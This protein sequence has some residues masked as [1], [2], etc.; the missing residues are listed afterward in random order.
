MT[1]RILCRYFQDGKFSQIFIDGIQNRIIEHSERM[2]LRGSVPCLPGVQSEFAT[3]RTDCKRSSIGFHGFR[4][5]KYL[6]KHKCCQ[7]RIRV[8]TDGGHGPRASAPATQ[9][10]PPEPGAGQAAAEPRGPRGPLEVSLRVLFWVCLGFFFFFCKPLN[11][12]ESILS[13]QARRRRAVGRVWPAG[14][15]VP[16]PLTVGSCVATRILQMG[17]PRGREARQSR[18]VTGAPEAASSLHGSV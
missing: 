1:Q 18:R 2:G 12:V 6:S 11:N 8:E 3:L 10:T 16:T 5:W 14:C 4:L 15:R 17:Q 13:P 9:L 7:T